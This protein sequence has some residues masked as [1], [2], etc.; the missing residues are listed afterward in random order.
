VQGL[1]TS[2]ADCWLE[3]KMLPEDPNVSQI[4]QGLSVDFLGS[5]QMPSQHKLQNFCPKTSHFTFCHS[6]TLQTKISEKFKV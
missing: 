6:E 3:V 5:R 2:M 1:A 4:D